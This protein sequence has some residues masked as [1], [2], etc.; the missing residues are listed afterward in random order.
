MPLYFST[1]ID[2]ELKYI[3]IR[4]N[5]MYVYRCQSIEITLTAGE[6]LYIPCGW[7]HEVRS[8]GPPAEGG[9]LAL[10]YW[11]H[12]PDGDSFHRPYTSDFWRADMKARVLES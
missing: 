3:Y 1:D 5:C 10:N 2:Q 4:M 8:L 12:P 9:H 11:F 6:M 7:F